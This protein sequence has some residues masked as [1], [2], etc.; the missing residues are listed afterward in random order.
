ME[1][2]RQLGS[3]FLE[4]VY[5][6]ALALEFSLNGIAFLREFPLPVKYKGHDVGKFRTDFLC[7][8]EIIVEIKAAT[9][10]APIDQSQLIHYLTASAKDIGL[11]INFGSASLEYRRLL[12]PRLIEA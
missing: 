7:F 11:L 12:Y 6:Q 8:G 1:V 10:L 9:N 2:H 3:G 5:Q 4:S